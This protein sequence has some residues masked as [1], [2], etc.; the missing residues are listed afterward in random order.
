MPS[1]PGALGLAFDE[2]LMGP[3]FGRELVGL[4][5]SFWPTDR[6]V[7]HAVTEAS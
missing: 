5:S 7:L 6:R 4:L 1:R 2:Q 3:T